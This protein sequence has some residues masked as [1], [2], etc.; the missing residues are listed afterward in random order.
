MI[1]VAAADY[2]SVNGE[3]TA[4]SGGIQKLAGG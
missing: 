3:A 4:T 2:D 1:Y